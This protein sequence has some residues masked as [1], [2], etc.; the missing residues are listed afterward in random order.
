MPPATTPPGPHLSPSQATAL[1][2]V[3]GPS[4]EMDPAVENVVERIHSSTVRIVLYLG[5]GASQ[6]PPALARAS[7]P[8]ALSLSW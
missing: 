4:S 5:G 3:G 2:G 6:V 7:P 8:S 1:A